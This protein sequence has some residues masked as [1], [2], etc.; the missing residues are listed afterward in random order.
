MAGPN[1]I[2]RKKYSPFVVQCVDIKLI[3]I[4]IN[5]REKGEVQEIELSLTL[6]M[7]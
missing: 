6:K 4:V 1:F 3:S 5:L 2:A 7:I